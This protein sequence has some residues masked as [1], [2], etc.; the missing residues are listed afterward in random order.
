VQQDVQIAADIPQDVRDQIRHTPLA[1]NKQELLR[2]ARH[3]EPTQ[4]KL[5]AKLAEGGVRHLY[6]ADRAVRLEEAQQRVKSLPK[7]TENCRLLACTC[8]E[9]VER[10]A[11]GSVDLI[12]T[13][14]PYGQDA[15]ASYG[16]LGRLGAH[17]LTPNGSML[18][19]IG[20]M[21]LFEVLQTLGEHLH[22]RWMLAYIVKSGG[23]P[24]VPT[25]QARVNSRWKPILW[26]TR[27]GYAGDVHGDL[28]DSGPKAKLN[29]EWEQDVA[30]MAR[31]TELFSL[32]GDL[33]CDPFLGTGTTAIAALRLQRL[34]VGCDKDDDRVNLARVRLAD[35]ETA[36]AA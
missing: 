12:L 5:A 16:E 26:F 15:L 14:P 19:M 32:P 28:I 13:D 29:H 27:S 24:V 33:V 4:R 23:S 31:L 17:A 18:V 21:H 2:L 7:D 6:E 8:G 36:K 25:V 11:P 10:I 30:G 9:L 3:D 34:F 1:E 20:Q 22:Y 35:V